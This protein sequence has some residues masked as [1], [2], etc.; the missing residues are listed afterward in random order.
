MNTNYKKLISETLK[1][2]MCNLYTKS[3]LFVQPHAGLFVKL[4]RVA[5]G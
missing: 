1:F 5:V 2:T 4:K 3:D